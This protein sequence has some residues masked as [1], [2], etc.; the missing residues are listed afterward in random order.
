VSLSSGSDFAKK[1]GWPSGLRFPLAIGHRGACGHATEN[2]L[3]SFGIASDLGAEM[4][5]LDTQLTRDG[6]CVVSHDDHLLRVFGVDVRISQLNA[7]EL[8]RVPNVEAPTFAEVAALASVRGAGLY[9]ELKA[10]GTGIPAWR[11]LRER[12]HRFAAFGSFNV[13]LVRELRDTGCDYPLSVL[14]PLGADPKAAADQAGADIIHLCWE[15][16]GDRPQDLVTGG[17]IEEAASA[18]RQLVLWHEERPP[19]IADLINLPVLGIC[20]DR[21]ELLRQTDSQTAVT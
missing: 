20:S 6:V 3:R 5:E 15:R 8:A 1:F 4:W 7:A 11:H 14:V 12:G 18:G 21:L 13:N 10:A 19:V 2:T 9:I 17:L 16:G